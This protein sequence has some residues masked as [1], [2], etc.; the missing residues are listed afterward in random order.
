MKDLNRTKEIE[1]KKLLICLGF[2]VFA[3]LLMAAEYTVD[4]V[5][6]LK[7]RIRNAA[8]GDTI[9][10]KAG[11]YDLSGETPVRQKDNYPLAYLVI[12]AKKLI[13]RGENEGSWKTKQR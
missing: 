3:S 4:S 12:N 10:L 7:T 5:S 11:V 9:I 13:L 8:T 1:M 6:S 2:S